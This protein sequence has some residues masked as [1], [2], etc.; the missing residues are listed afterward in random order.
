MR[1]SAVIFDLFGTL[2]AFSRRENDRA[3]AQ[4]AE[5]LNA[6]ALQFS[7]LM[8][9]TYFNRCTGVYASIEENVLDVC[10]R[11]G[12]QANMVQITQATKSHY[13][14]M[15][16]ALIPKQEVLEALE[17]LK[18]SGFLLGLISNC[19]PTVPLLFPQSP[20]AQYIDVPIFSCE[21]G[22]KKPSPRI[23]QLTCERLRVKPEE[24]LYVGDGSSEELT[25][26]AAIGMLPIL[27]RAD[28]MDVYDPRRPEV[29]SWRRRVIDKIGEVSEILSELVRL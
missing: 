13:E 27:K 1:Y 7:R 5:T 19:S 25:G 12:I 3:T 10:S 6:P 2:V 26:A 14:F 15:A 4:I 18:N 29:E 16:N 28:L 23:Y 22:I 17:M 20:L 21:A 24:C 11:L 8:G 9:E